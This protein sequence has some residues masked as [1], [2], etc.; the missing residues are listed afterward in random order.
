MYRNL[1]AYL[2]VLSFSFL[3]GDAFAHPIHKSVIELDYK[4]GSREMHVMVRIFTDD[5]EQVLFE[6]SG[7]PVDLSTDEGRSA[8]KSVI[9]KYVSK[10]VRIGIDDEKR[11]MKYVGCENETEATWCYFVISDVPKPTT[12][13]ITN[14]ILFSL[15][16]D[17]ENIANI[18]VGE[19]K[20]MI[21]TPLSRWGQLTF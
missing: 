7:E 11:I 6:E 2:F 15:Y 12:F 20:S 9:T 4:A 17:Q 19:T 1:I 13:D 18:K 3:F 10:V 14:T 16:D 5:F 8:A 21:F